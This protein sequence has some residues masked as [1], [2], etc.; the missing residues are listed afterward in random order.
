MKFQDIDTPAL[1]IDRERLEANIK[2]M[3]DF[4]NKHGVALRPHSKTH[5]MPEIAKRT[6]TAGACGIAVAKVGEAEA[7]AFA[8]ITDIFIANQIVGDIKLKKIRRLAE[9][10]N[11]SFG[12]DSPCHVEAIQRVFADAPKPA[13][14]LIEIEVGENRSG[15]IEEED[16]LVLLETIKKC[17][18]VHLK[19]LF[20]HDG[21]TYGA[22]SV[23][24]C[25]EIAVEAQKRTVHFAKLAEE[26]GLKCEVVSYGSTPTLMNEIPIVE[27]ITEL[28][29]G[30]YIFM[31]NAQGN[32]IGTLDR[33][34]ATVLATVISKPTPERTIM[35]AGAKALTKETRVGGICNTE[36]MGTFY[37]Y[38]HISVTKLYDEHTIIINKE[39]H[40][41]VEIGDK[42]RI[43]PVHICPVCNLYDKAYLV[44]GD[45]VIEELEVAGRGKIC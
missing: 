16:F 13:E 33:C 29:P 27:G 12:I 34:A 9:V 1:L 45:E 18:M 25:A 31:D 20:S 30:T 11:I 5:K 24:A 26:Q 37:E 42:L 14:V 8:G 21:N 38:P 7:M 10:I 3:Q 17:P 43:I 2:F 6:L 28:R 23:E 44:S 39:L 22:P 4:A 35:D 36:G 15:I 40:D 19:G 32:A 41:L